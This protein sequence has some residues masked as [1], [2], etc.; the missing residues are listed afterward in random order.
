MRWDRGHQSQ[1]VRDERNR[2]ALGAGMGSGGILALFQIASRFGWKGI[3]AAGV[4]LAGLY[5]VSS[6][7]SGLVGSG[8]SGAGDE[9]FQFVS[10]VLDDV[11]ST[12][13]ATLPG[14]R[15]AK[16]VVYRG[17][18]S[19]G[20]GYGSAATGPFYCPLDQQVY[21]DLSFYDELASR[22]GAPGDFAEAYVVAHEVGHHV[23][24]LVGADE[25]VGRSRQGANSG[26]VRLELQ[27][28][29]YAGVWAAAAQKRGILEVGDLE[30][31]LRAA[32]AIG[33]DPSATLDGWTTEGAVSF[34]HGVSVAEDETVAE[35]W[36]ALPDQ[37]AA[38]S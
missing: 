13:D 38:R 2:P 32:A 34:G 11:Q 18:T 29:C 16:L 9:K 37:V 5:A 15:H 31:G 22:F 25:K 17:S 30:E 6:F 10:F 36:L 3:V 20:C 19:T 23:Q 14:Y 33:D 8:P 28:D 7:Q 26:S 27:A 21:I 35:E 1:D 12:W 24:H 4:L